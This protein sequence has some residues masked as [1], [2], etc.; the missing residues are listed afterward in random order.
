[1]LSLNIDIIPEPTFPNSFY[2]SQSRC[3][4]AVAPMPYPVGETRPVL[5]LP[6]LV[7]AFVQ[8]AETDDS[9]DASTRIRKG[10]LHFLASVFANLTTASTLPQC[11]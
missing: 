10:H 6:L 2:P 4:T 7:D 11:V 5:A 8:G 3:A 1:M 9:G